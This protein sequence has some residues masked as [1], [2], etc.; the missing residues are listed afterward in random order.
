M[1]PGYRASRSSTASPWRQH[2]IQTELSDDN[3]DDDST[4]QYSEED[5]DVLKKCRVS[6]GLSREYTPTWR[7]KDAFRELYQNW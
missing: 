4:I 7:P 3:D 5:P 2:P 6:L 1:A